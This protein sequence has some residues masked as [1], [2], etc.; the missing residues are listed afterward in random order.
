MIVCIDADTNTV[1]Y[2]KKQLDEQMKEE[3]KADNKAI[4]F[5]VQKECI[6]IWVPKRQIENW[7]CFLRG[8]DTTEDKDYRHSGN[9]PDSCKYEAKELLRYFMGEDDYKDVLP[10]IKSARKEYEK[11]C[12]LQI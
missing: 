4:T 9:T 7:I 3:Q 12:N 1:D 11:V 8:E 10:S 2:R 6:M 5:D